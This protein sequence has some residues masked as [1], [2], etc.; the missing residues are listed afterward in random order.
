MERVR[1]HQGTRR[2]PGEDKLLP[3]L[4]GPVW[5]LRPVTSSEWASPCFLGLGCPNFQMGASKFSE[6]VVVT[7]WWQP[8]SQ[9]SAFAHLILQWPRGWGAGWSFAPAL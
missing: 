6:C 9:G 7:C 4:F 2:R 5:A 1:H 8:G 3:P